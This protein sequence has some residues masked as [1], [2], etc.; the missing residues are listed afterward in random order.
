MSCEALA[1]SF[2]GPEVLKLDWSTRALNVSDMD[3][4]G[5]ND[6]VVINNDTAKIEILYQLAEGTDGMNRKRQ[7]KRNRWEPVLEDAR[8]WSETITIGFP[9]F[10]LAIGDLNGDGRNDLAYT[11]R[12][13]PLTVRFQGESKNWTEAEEFGGFEFIQSFDFVKFNN[14]KYIHMKTQLNK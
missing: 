14:F 3:G 5:L 8:F 11:G 7:L 9:L 2:S 4:D 10:D 1:L 12:E 6:L 13:S